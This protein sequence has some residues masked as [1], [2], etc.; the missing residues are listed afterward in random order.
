MSVIDDKFLESVAAGTQT[1]E[2]AK[3]AIWMLEM[4]SSAR[5]IEEKLRNLIGG[6][7]KSC[8]ATLEI[9]KWVC[10]LG[11]G[12]EGSHLDNGKC[13]V[14]AD[15]PAPAPLPEGPAIA[16]V[17][18]ASVAARAQVDALVSMVTAARKIKAARDSR[19]EQIVQHPLRPG[20][21]L[22]TFS[23]AETKA[24]YDTQNA[25]IELIEALDLYEKAG[26]R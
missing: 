19:P 24:D 4:R 10:D 1:C 13:G 11:F 3:L 7:R 25:V 15:E 16:A 18:R 5:V 6:R 26:G 14:W 8:S 12:H 2:P 23:A 17:E 9:H 20:L 22:T 21:P